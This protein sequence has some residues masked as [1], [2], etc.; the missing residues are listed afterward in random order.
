MIDMGFAATDDNDVDSD[1]NSNDV[2]IPYLDD[3]VV[4]GVARSRDFAAFVLI[5]LHNAS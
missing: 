2:V 1:D 3:I 5:L 4:A